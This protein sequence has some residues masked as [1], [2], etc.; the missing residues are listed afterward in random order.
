MSPFASWSLMAISRWFDLPFAPVAIDPPVTQPSERDSMIGFRIISR[1]LGVLC[2]GA[3]A[4]W[5]P[6][7][8]ESLRR[9]GD[10]LPEAS[11][12]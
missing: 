12:A 7:D 2:L 8:V 9:A 1:Y 10:V 4:V 5:S 6:E 11:G 3:L